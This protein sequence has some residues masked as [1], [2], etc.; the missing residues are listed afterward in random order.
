MAWTAWNRN[1]C[2]PCF[3]KHSQCSCMT[4]KRKVYCITSNTWNPFVSA[5]L[6]HNAWSQWNW[7][8]NGLLKHF[9]TLGQ[10]T[11][12]NLSPLFD[13]AVIVQKSSDHF[14][15]VGRDHSHQEADQV[16]SIISLTHSGADLCYG[17]PMF[18]RGLIHLVLWKPTSMSEMSMKSILCA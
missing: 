1:Q 8:A 15:C 6:F 3:H 12:L 10:T 16:I 11:S 9:G 2:P 4:H 7:D 14:L 17:C 13:H 5:A 18:W